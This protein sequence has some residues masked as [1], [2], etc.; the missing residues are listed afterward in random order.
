KR[1]SADAVVNAFN[2]STRNLYTP[3]YRVE[4]VRYV[5]TFTGL[6]ND[7]LASGRRVEEQ[8]SLEASVRTQIRTQYRNEVGVN[9][10]NEVA[11]LTLLQ[12]NYNASARVI[13]VANQMLQALEQ[14]V[15]R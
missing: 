4:N 6:T 13:S 14:I 9:I 11:Q 7:I 12:N 10:D 5:E 1:N 8:A 3:G 2:S 15:G